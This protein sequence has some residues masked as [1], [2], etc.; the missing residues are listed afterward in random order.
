MTFFF[1]FRFYVPMIL[2]C[3]SMP[4]AAAKEE[5]TT[6]DWDKLQL[7]LAPLLQYW[8]N[9]NNGSSS[10]LQVLGLASLPAAQRTGILLGGLTFVTTITAVLLLLYCGG[11]W[12]RIAQE[13]EQKDHPLSPAERS[14][15]RPLLYETLL[16]QRARFI[17]EYEESEKEVAKQK[18][19][20]TTPTTNHTN[21]TTTVLMRRMQNVA[22]S[23]PPTPTY[24]QL[25]QLAYRQCQDRPGGTLSIV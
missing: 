4:L 22:P 6:S 2:L 3:V 8:N 1:M 17:Q 21:D 15:Q 14:A 12:T 24:Q 18:N 13:E 16:E 7:A 23:Q 9:P 5:D 20:T 10:L 25:Y 11:T 19:G